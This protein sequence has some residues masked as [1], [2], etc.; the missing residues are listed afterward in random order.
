MSINGKADIK[1][2]VKTVAG[3]S[4]KELNKKIIKIYPNSFK[5]LRKMNLDLHIKPKKNIL[6]IVLNIHLWRY[7]LIYKKKSK[8]NLITWKILV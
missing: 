2:I 5:G 6:P 8:K 3:K 1:K 4:E 7:L